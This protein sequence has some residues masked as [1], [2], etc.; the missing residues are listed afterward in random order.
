M[1]TVIFFLCKSTFVGFVQDARFRQMST[2]HTPTCY[3]VMTAINQGELDFLAMWVIET[4]PHYK[5]E[6]D[7][8]SEVMKINKSWYQQQVPWQVR[9]CLVECF[10]PTVFVDFAYDVIDDASTYDCVGDYFP[11]EYRAQSM[12]SHGPMWYAGTYIVRNHDT[13]PYD[14]SDSLHRM[15]KMGEAIF[16]AV[17]HDEYRKTLKQRD[18]ATGEKI[19][20]EDK[21]TRSIHRQLLKLSK[22]VIAEMILLATGKLAQPIHSRPG[23]SSSSSSAA[24]A[25]PGLDRCTSTLLNLADPSLFTRVMTP[26]QGPHQTQG[27]FQADAVEEVFGIVGAAINAHMGEL[28]SRL[29]PDERLPES[30]IM[31]PMVL[32]GNHTVKISKSAGQR[33]DNQAVDPSPVQGSGRQRDARE[34]RPR[35]VDAKAKAKGK[36]QGSDEEMGKGGE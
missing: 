6:Y 4:I 29:P 14:S 24:A 17:V 20:F 36:A 33:S 26:P 12:D 1:Y 8:S 21:I 3:K 2:V 30:Q 16:N 18:L 32:G 23:S 13:M 22:E 27:N 35:R 19:P 34:G 10:V 5:S 31:V 28:N 9:H 11:K 7:E 25:T 15:K